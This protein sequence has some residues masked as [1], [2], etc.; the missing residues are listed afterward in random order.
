MN[1]KNRTITWKKIVENTELNKSLQ[2][3]LS[4]NKPQFKTRF[5][6]PLQLDTEKGYEITLTNSSNR[7]TYYSFANI[8]ETN[9]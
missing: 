6:P 5:Y 1:I 4:S 9:N 3:I 8:N 7:K 2:I